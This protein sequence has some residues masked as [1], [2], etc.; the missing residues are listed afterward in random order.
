MLQQVQQPTLQGR[1]R[2]KQC[3]MPAH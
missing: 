3:S 1:C 2:A